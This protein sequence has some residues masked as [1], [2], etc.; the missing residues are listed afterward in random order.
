M[1]KC[2]TARQATDDVQE[3]SMLDNEGYRH[4]C[5]I[6][7]TYCFS[8]AVVVAQMHLNVTF[9]HTLPALLIMYTTFNFLI[10]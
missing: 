5:G 10:K 8:T 9:I 3:H 1:E 4:T 7:N 6:C 2:G